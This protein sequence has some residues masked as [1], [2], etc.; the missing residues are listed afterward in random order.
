MAKSVGFMKPSGWN[1][2][3]DAYSYFSLICPVSESG[4]KTTAYMKRIQI[5]L[6]AL[7]LIPACVLFAQT[8]DTK[9]ELPL[10]VILLLDLSDRLVKTSGQAEKDKTIIL[11]IMENFEKRQKRMSY[12]TSK[13]ILTV[14]VAAQ[15][16][17]GTQSV[18]DMRIDMHTA[19][20]SS[21]EIG[22]PLFK[23]RKEAFVKA[24]DKLYSEA[25]RSPFTGAD[26]YTFLCTDYPQNYML[27]SHRNKVIILTDGYLTFDGQFSAQ[28]PKGTYMAGLDTMRKAKDKWKETFAKNNLK[29]KPCSNKSYV[30][31]E[32]ILVETAPLFKGTS[33]HE[34]DIVQHY[35]KTWLDESGLKNA[36]IEKHDAL[37]D[38]IKAK[39]TRFLSQ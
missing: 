26:I 9:A 36:W 3:F 16:Q 30:R 39:I 12:L 6:L 27:K 34:Y 13:D 2:P 24:L 29:L 1:R 22:Y 14:A 10:N 21:K 5:L 33:V 35:W 23:K 31:T 25:L 4:I 8:P 18:N 38:N 7:W 17:V 37:T 20:G 19:L 32:L 15:P 28:R 11:G